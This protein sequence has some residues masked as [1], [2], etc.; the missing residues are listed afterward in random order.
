MPSPGSP[1]ISFTV[2]RID[3]TEH[4]LFAPVTVDAV[5]T[6]LQNRPD[7]DAPSAFPPVHLAIDHPKTDEDEGD[8]NGGVQ[9]KP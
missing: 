2:P 1:S 4:M 6:L 5:I 8:E 7:A 3:V 9:Q